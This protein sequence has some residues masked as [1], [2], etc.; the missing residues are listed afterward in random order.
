[1]GLIHVSGGLQEGRW[2]IVKGSQGLKAT[3]TSCRKHMVSRISPKKLFPTAC[4]C[5]AIMTC[6]EAELA[7]LQA[8]AQI[9]TM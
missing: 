8:S 7:K 6:V 9:S 5:G 2:S 4:S 3:C 1:M